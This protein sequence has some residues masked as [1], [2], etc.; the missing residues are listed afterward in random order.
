[1]Q[2]WESVF[3]IRT[4]ALWWKALLMRS[5]HSPSGQSMINPPDWICCHQEA[6]F[7]RLFISH[8]LSNGPSFLCIHCSHSLS[9]QILHRWLLGWLQGWKKLTGHHIAH[10][11][12]KNWKQWHLFLR[13]H[14]N[15]EH[16]NEEALWSVSASV[17][18]TTISPL[19]TLFFWWSKWLQDFMPAFGT[20]DIFHVLLL[21][22]A[23][24]KHP[25]A[26][27]AITEAFEEFWLLEELD[28]LRQNPAGA[29][30]KPSRL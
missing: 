19:K 30:K 10:L 21:H 28:W 14:V 13:L 3:Q 7:G 4:R 11:H 20:L 18:P 25:R 6:S 8:K 27:T 16:I 5:S 1:M 12:M 26:S 24:G 15:E 9:F 2:W 23:G 29:G 17:P 22:L